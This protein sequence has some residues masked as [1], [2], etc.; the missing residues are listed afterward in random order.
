VLPGA[1]SPRSTREARCRCFAKRAS[2]PYGEVRTPLMGPQDAETAGGSVNDGGRA[3]GKS[4]V[5]HVRGVRR[6]R[7]WVGLDYAARR[8]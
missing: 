5:G 2:D 3:E 8:T 7:W 4:R 1:M 6:A